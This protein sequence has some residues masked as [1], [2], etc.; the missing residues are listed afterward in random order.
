M[1][2][3]KQVLLQR[4]IQYL[5]AIHHYCQ[6]KGATFKEAYRAFGSFLPKGDIPFESYRRAKEIYNANI[7]SIR[8]AI[9][10]SDAISSFF[11]SPPAI[12]RGAADNHGS[13]ILNGRVT[14]TPCPSL[15]DREEWRSFIMNELRK[16]LSLGSNRIDS[17]TLEFL[18]TTAYDAL[19]DNSG[20]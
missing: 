17:P 6:E 7:A 5:A 9:V 10:D 20:M 13:P 8:A 4:R 12:S 15:G 1:T 3:H 16:D 2:D 14:T 11:Q 19:T 18:L